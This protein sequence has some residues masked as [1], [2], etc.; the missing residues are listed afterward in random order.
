MHQANVEKG[1]KNRSN[2]DKHEASGPGEGLVQPQ[3]RE[4]TCERSGLS[5]ILR[6]HPKERHWDREEL[7]KMDKFIC[8]VPLVV[9]D[10]IAL[11]EWRA[12][13]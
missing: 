1:L 5:T 13:W 3:K 10:E 11:L 2:A 4:L 8:L 12:F 7:V 6:E 9:A